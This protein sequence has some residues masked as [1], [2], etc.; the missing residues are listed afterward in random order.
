MGDYYYYYITTDTLLLL[1]HI[2]LIPHKWRLSNPIYTQLHYTAPR[3][4]IVLSLL[5]QEGS[6]RI[7]DSTI[8]LMARASQSHSSSSLSAV[9]TSYISLLLLLVI[10]LL[11]L[12]VILLLLLL[13]LVILL[14]QLLLHNT[15]HFLVT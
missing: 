15:I 2:V 12:L 8:S 13:L 10:L 14:L 9:H 1:L 5:V 4:P 11:L 7:T 3:P 6:Q